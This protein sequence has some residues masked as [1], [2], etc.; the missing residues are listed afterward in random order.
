M[1][2]QHKSWIGRNQTGRLS[3]EQRF[4]EKVEIA[5]ENECWNWTGGLTDGYGIFS[6]RERNVLAHRLSWELAFGK[7]PEGLCILH[8]CDNPRCVNPSHLFLGTREDNN[9]DRSSKGRD[10]SAKG[11]RNNGAK[12]TAKQVKTIRE[13]YLTGEFSQLA[14]GK[15]F[16]ISESEV[17][18]IVNLITWKHVP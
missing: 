10:G 15:M 6:T 14:I 8:E 13:M 9:R 16:G 11:E 5:S 7:I 4:W 12:I 1:P 18:N 3:Q 2:A 17:G